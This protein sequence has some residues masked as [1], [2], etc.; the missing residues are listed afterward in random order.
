MNLCI[1]KNFT[2]VEKCLDKYIKLDKFLK[3]FNSFEYLFNLQKN[4]R[5]DCSVDYIYKKEIYEDY[6]FFN[7]LTQEEYNIEVDYGQQKKNLYQDLKSIEFDDFNFDDCKGY[8]FIS[9]II[10]LCHDFVLNIY[11]KKI[12][13]DIYPTLRDFCSN[14]ILS[15]KNT[16]IILDNFEEIFL[17]NPSLNDIAQYIKTPSSFI[18]LS[19]DS[20]ENLYISTEFTDF[21]TIYEDDNFTD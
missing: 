11:N 6:I 12:Q 19:W 15:K 14:I 4:I 8:V 18:D 2:P 3:E 13:T 17:K 20:K 5:Y 7:N 21:H 16:F 10:E 9:M 1:L